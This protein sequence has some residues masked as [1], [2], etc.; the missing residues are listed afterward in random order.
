ML[1][2]RINIP[3]ITAAIVI[4]L[5]SAGAVAAE[6][7]SW[8]DCVARAAINNFGIRGAREQLSSATSREKGSKS[9]FM[10]KVTA[11]AGATRSDGGS[12]V[13]GDNSSTSASVT[14]SQNL[15]AGFGDA[16]LMKKSEADRM[17]TDS[18]L[19]QAKVQVSYNLKS[20][21]ASLLYAQKYS[22][23][24]DK[25]I[26]RREENARLVELHY[27]SGIENKGSVMLARA[28]VGQAKYE[29][30]V[31]RGSIGTN[32]AQLA[33]S[34]GMNPSSDIEI[35]S[36]IPLT[37]PGAEP[38]YA[39]LAKATP[40]FRKSD[41]ERMA[42]AAG[43]EVARSKFF[44]SVDLAGT[45]SSSGSGGV[46]SGSRRAL[47][48]NVSLPVFAGGADYYEYKS[49]V[50][51]LAASSYQSSDTFAQLIPRL[52]EAYQNFVQAVFKF[53]VDRDFLEA[54][55]VRAEIAKNKYNNGLISFEDWDVI[56]NDL[57]SKQKALIQ[58]ERDRIVAEA[59][60][61]LVRG[62]GEIQ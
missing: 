43:V 47:S 48:L 37:E 15:F 41:E 17:A 6:K 14:V 22:A 5:A 23:L 27:D 49:S 1:N 11:E 29:K 30:V 54:A 60:W 9:G 45:L 55:E 36:T 34:M 33:S 4:M 21:F 16:A 50:A 59:N 25:I 58:S 32:R 2:R 12:A 40:E 53:R 31:A 39:E 61:N 51:D 10:P 18:N 62:V 19:K 44:P 46:P 42:S 3:I 35:V 24:A 20:S 38:N 52:K 7:L 13:S 28:F 56:E 57:I 26:K 8:S